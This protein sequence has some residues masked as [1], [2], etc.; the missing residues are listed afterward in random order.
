[1]HDDVN[2]FYVTMLNCTNIK[3]YENL[4]WYI[5]HTKICT[6]K[7]YP[8]YGITCEMV[9]NFSINLRVK[10]WCITMHGIYYSPCMQL[11]LGFCD[12]HACMH[13]L[14]LCHM[15]TVILY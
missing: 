14:H 1:M 3:K 2:M 11:N 4:I 8:L 13:S 5:V 7:N 6:T 15:Q 9:G 10:E 12:K